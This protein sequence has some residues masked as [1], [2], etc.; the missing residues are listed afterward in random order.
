MSNR[1]WLHYE[2]G[3]QKIIDLISLLTLPLSV[4]GEGFRQV[5]VRCYSEVESRKV[6]KKIFPLESNLT[7]LEVN[8]G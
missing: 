3:V 4:L 1:W 7:L 8:L 6:L 2:F 5:A